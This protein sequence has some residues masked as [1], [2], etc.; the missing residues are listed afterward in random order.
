MENI[1][2]TRHCITT[3]LEVANVTNKELDFIRNFRHL[4]LIFVTHIVLFLL[5]TTKNA[6]LSDI[7]FQKTIKYSIT[8]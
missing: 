6:N 3:T 4:C 1:V 5:I 2:N 8:E 7:C